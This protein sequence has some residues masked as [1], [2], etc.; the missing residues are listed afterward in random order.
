MNIPIRPVLFTGQCIQSEL[1]HG[2]VLAQDFQAIL[3]VSPHPPYG[4]FILV[5]KGPKDLVRSC[6]HTL[7]PSTQTIYIIR[8]TAQ[9][10]PKGAHIIPLSDVTSSSLENLVIINSLQNKNKTKKGTN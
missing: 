6:S 9:L 1:C 4:S 10:Q 5:V 2:C 7:G 3:D 8:V